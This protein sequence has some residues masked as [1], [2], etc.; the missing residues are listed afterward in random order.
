MEW[1]ARNGD[2]VLSLLTVALIAV[3]QDAVALGLDARS[4]AW[5]ALGAGVITAA[6]TIF[7]PNSA[8][9]KGPVA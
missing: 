6:H 1:F 3:S 5:C 9:P 4:V 7:Y 2:K 8:P